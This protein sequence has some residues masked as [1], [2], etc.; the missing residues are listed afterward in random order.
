MARR[1]LCVTPFF[2]LAMIGLS[3]VAPQSADAQVANAGVIVDADGVLRKKV[4][5]DPTGALARRRVAEARAKLDPDLMR[6]S[7]LRKVSLNRLEEAIAARLAAGQ[8]ETD[9]MRYLAGLTKIQYVF[10][11]PDTNDIVIAGPAEGY[12]EDLSGRPIGVHSGRSILE[13]QDLIVA[14]RAFPPTGEKTGVIGVSIDPTKE[15]LTKMR[16]FL[17]SLRGISPRDANRIAMGLRSNL[18]LQVVSIQ[19][20]SPQSHFAQVLVEADYRMKLIGIGLEKP[21]V[22]IPSYV[23]RAN[24]RDVA[25]NAMQRW[26]FMPDYDCVCVSDDRL[27]MELVGNGVKLVGENEMV[28]ATGGR[29]ASGRVDR[30]SQTFV[31]AFTKKYNELAKREPV[32]AQMRNLIDMS[33]A[34][35]FIQQ[36]DYYGQAG[37]GMEVFGSEDNLKVETYNTPKQVESAVNVVWKGNTL[38]TPIGGGVNIQ[39]QMALAT[40]RLVSDENNQ[41]KSARESIKIDALP[42]NRWWWD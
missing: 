20:V 41:V 24:P 33:I 12:V 34:A 39:P 23:S 11:Y 18:G 42:K 27:A 16:Q 37:W 38:M 25:R 29:A 31:T 35:A 32:Y 40:D 8:P 13:L 22:A 6:P 9:D 10:F 2:A 17:A 3:L 26:Y 28:D 36:Q 21:P 30:A 4:H 15:G 14:L 5:H 1:F 7:K 19:G